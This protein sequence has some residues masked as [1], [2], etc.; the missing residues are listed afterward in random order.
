MM[1]GAG[2][3]TAGNNT[4][5]TNGRWGD[6]SGMSVDPYSPTT[7]WFTSEYYQSTSASTWATRIGCFTFGNVFSSAASAYPSTV[8]GGD[9]VQLKDVPYGGS[10]VYTYSW[11]SIPPGF[12]STSKTPK[13][14]PSDTT[15]YICTV[16]DGTSVRHDTTWANVVP[17]PT[18]NVGP[19]TLVCWFATKIT[20]HATATHYRMLGWQTTGDGT[21]S[22][23]SSPTTDY[24][25]GAGDKT[26]GSVTLKLIAI[27]N[28][29]C[30]TNVTSSRIVTFDPCSGVDEKSAVPVMLIRPNPATESVTF[31]F[32]GLRDVPAVLTITGMDG[33]V[34]YTSTITPSGNKAV[35]RLDLSGFAKGVYLVQIKSDAQVASQRLIVQ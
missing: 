19:D 26:N 4:G 18:V 28:I 24:T 13:A 11:S 34:R 33:Q 5:A 12:T 23:T 8:C 1:A 15:T 35:K 16:S 31:T 6:Y 20:L 3:Q 27:P 22:S 32:A 2:S 7:F 25:F 10:G 17:P 21:F 29:P 9:S 14:G 30:N